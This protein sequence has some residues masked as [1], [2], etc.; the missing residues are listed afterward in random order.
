M[1]LNKTLIPTK[2]I[3]SG[4]P[5]IVFLKL[6][7]FSAIIVFSFSGGKKVLEVYKK[8]Y[9]KKYGHKQINISLMPQVYSSGY[10]TI[11]S[12]C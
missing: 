6:L 7:R 1:S 5:K 3:I 8:F 4:R 12:K 11:K 10:S 2:L 9:P